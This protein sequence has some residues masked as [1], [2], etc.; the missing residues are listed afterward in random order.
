MMQ[1]FFTQYAGAGGDYADPRISPL[2]ANSLEGLPPA[3][4]IV[5]E[6]DPLLDEGVAY[7]EALEAA[8]VTVTLEQTPGHVHDYVMNLG[9]IDDAE[10]AIADAARRMTAAWQ[11]V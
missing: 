9:V 2:R 3:H 7:A 1:W 11:Q 5:A 4:V 6:Y 10:R 8:G